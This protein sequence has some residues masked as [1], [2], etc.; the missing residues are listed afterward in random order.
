MFGAFSISFG[1]QPGLFGISLLLFPSSSHL[2]LLPLPCLRAS[3]WVSKRHRQLGFFIPLP[4]HQN[5]TQCLLL[6]GA[7][8]GCVLPMSSK[9]VLLPLSCSSRPTLVACAHGFFSPTVPIPVHPHPYEASQT[10][11]VHLPVSCLLLPPGGNAQICGLRCL[12]CRVFYTA[13]ILCCLPSFI[14]KGQNSMSQV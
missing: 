13:P 5:Q 10:K 1:S 4:Y 7:A 2:F 11:V 9:L 14:F 12:R 6:L 8:V 3:F